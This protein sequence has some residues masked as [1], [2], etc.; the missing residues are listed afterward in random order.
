M[1][2]PTCSMWGLAEIIGGSTGYEPFLFCAGADGAVSSFTDLYIA[3]RASAFVSVC[4]PRSLGCC[5]MSLIADT[6]RGEWTILMPSAIISSR[7]ASFSLY[8]IKRNAPK[9]ERT[10]AQR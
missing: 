8:L 1:N 4:C 10:A 3:D 6:G 7:V 5:S 2:G 9:N